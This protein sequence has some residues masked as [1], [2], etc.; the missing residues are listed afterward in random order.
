MAIDAP[1][2]PA[3]IRALNAGYRTSRRVGRRPL[4]LRKYHLFDKA[5]RKAGGLTDFGD[6]RFETGLDQ[7]I[8]SIEDEDRLNGLGRIM[9][10]GHITNLLTQRLLMTAHLGTHPEI[11]D[12]RIEKPIFIIGAP[13][14]GTTI[15]HHLLSQDDRFRFPY[16][17][18]VDELHPPLNPATMQHDPRIEPSQKN[19]DRISKLAPDLDAAHPVGAWE[20][21]ECALLHA[22][23][24]H[25]GTFH[26]MFN[27]Q[28]YDRWLADQDMTWVYEQQKLMLKY[29]QSGGLRPTESWLLKTPP[30]MENIDRI[31]TVFP[32]ARFIT[33]YREP[34][35][36]VASSCSLTR[37]LIQIVEDN[38]DWHDHGRHL[39]WRVG[40]MLDRNVELRQRYAHL[41]ERFV[42][43]PMQRMVRDPLTCVT[44][45]YDSFN[46]DLPDE[47]RG[48]MQTFMRQRDRASRPPHIYDPADYGLD[49]AELWPRF[50]NYRK[51]YG[52]D[53]E[54]RG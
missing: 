4:K 48:K 50:E 34:T 40:R 1:P 36:V 53:G 20:A 17:W 51:F 19:L 35:E 22:Y 32:D 8:T 30:H 52:I 47:T 6:R 46:I 16:T 27:C 39:T 29:M 31:L 42:D 38:P 25:A 45:I 2:M 7:L 44:E 23:E 3:P 5:S 15:T 43:F 21:Q 9:A 18:E 26:P 13:R 12:E 24:F 49:I 33:T 54:A 28:D 14:T 10:A 37:S 41:S 11:H